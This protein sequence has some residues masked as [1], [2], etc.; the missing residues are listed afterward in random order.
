MDIFRSKVRRLIALCALLVIGFIMPVASHAQT[1]E[2]TAYSNCTSYAA[3]WTGS[4][5]TI[6][7]NCS[8]GTHAGSNAFIFE[9]KVASS[10]ADNINYYP[11]SGSASNPCAAI[12]MPMNGDYAGPL[13]QNNYTMTVPT[14]SFGATVNCLVNVSVQGTPVQ[15]AYG[16]WHNMLTFSNPASLASVG[17]GSSNAAFVGVTGSV[18]PTQPTAP[19][20]SAPPVLCGGGSCYD[21]GTNTYT[22]VTPSGQQITVAGPTANSSSGGCASSGSATMCAGNPVPPSPV[23]QSG[24]TITDPA[25]Q[26]QS[27]DGYTIADP[28]TGA[29]SATTVNVFSSGGATSSGATSGSVSTN[30]GTSTSTVSGGSSPAGSSSSGGGDSF[31]GGGNCNS[32]PVCSGDAVMCGVAQEAWFTQC[33]VSIQTTAMVGSNPTQ[34]PPTFQSDSTKYSQSDVW[35]QSDTSQSSTVGGQANNGTYD[36]SGFGYGTTCPLTDISVP[37]FGSSFAVPLSVGCVIGPW[38][39]ALII[40]FA[41]YSA[42]KITAGGNG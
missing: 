26:I 18:L 14:T 30:R 22:A 11:F 42:A 10:G 33:N 4:N 16:H 40:G 8:L 21:A 23:G 39:R 15:D 29:V 31:N 5:Y 34:Q 38:L 17:S 20:S 27:S 36:S 37:F 19:S 2:A 28:G 7:Q 32:P 25:T 41:L 9:F 12:S 6:V 1:T 3:Q 13:I 24:S 35:Q